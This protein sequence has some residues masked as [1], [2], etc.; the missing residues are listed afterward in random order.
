M[1]AGVEHEA[2]AP[3]ARPRES[4]GGIGGA[5]SCEVVDLSDLFGAETPLV[6]RGLVDGSGIL[7]DIAASS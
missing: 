3:G 1:V 5:P 6:G 7:L 2:G 4:A